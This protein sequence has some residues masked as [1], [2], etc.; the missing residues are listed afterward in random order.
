MA[1]TFVGT[2]PHL[3]FHLQKAV[4]NDA[5]QLWYAK[6]SDS[7]STWETPIA[8]PRNSSSTTEFH[9]TQWYEAIS[10]QA[11]GRVSVAAPWSSIGTQV[12]CNGP[13]LARSTDGLSFTTCSPM[14]SPV[15]RAGD[16]IS[17]WSHRAGKETIVFSY[18]NRANPTLKAGIA[19]WREP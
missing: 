13:K 16:W 8:I 18:D 10:I 9:S 3:A 15:Q 5:T 2:T 14:G 4:A 7:G 1:L 11:T 19:L 12:N 6:A 17:M